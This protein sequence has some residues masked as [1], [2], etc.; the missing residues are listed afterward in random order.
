M[1]AVLQS[2]GAYQSLRPQTSS[3]GRKDGTD[4]SGASDFVANI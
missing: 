2:T 4:V 1:Y 3:H